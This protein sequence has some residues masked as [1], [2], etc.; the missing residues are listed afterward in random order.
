MG[1]GAYEV[2]IGGAQPQVGP[3]VTE[4]GSEGGYEVHAV[5]GDHISAHPDAIGCVVERDL[6]AVVLGPVEHE[7]AD[8]R[9]TEQA[10][11]LSLAIQDVVNYWAIITP[12]VYFRI[13]SAKLVFICRYAGGRN[14]WAMN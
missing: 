6:H 4:A 8:I 14:V 10:R 12:S 1:C 2:P 9:P 13:N 11:N 3:I 5:G 7:R